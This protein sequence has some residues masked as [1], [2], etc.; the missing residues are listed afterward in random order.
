MYK[1]KSEKYNDF[2]IKTFIHFLI[3]NSLNSIFVCL[4]SEKT[5]IKSS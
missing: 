2:V 4:L 1:R 5:S 3:A